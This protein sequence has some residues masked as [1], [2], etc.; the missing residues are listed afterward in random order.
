MANINYHGYYEF[1]NSVVRVNNT[2]DTKFNVKAG[3]HQGSV[4]S[5][6][7][8]IMVL[9]VLSREFKSGLPWKMLC[10]DD[11]VII[12]ESL[13]EIEQKFMTWKNNIESKGL[14]VNIGKT[15]IMK[16]GT[17]AGPVFASGKYPCG[18]CKKGVD[19]NSL[20]C[21]FCKHWVHKRCSG[22]KG[23][24]IDTPI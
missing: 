15:M 9:E 12:A 11:L 6:L 16:C 4:L 3:V 19:R 2:V 23:R 5:P 18:M 8:F 24:L 21:S 13:L 10:T 20:Y 22:F 1:S 14:K 17:N 7:L